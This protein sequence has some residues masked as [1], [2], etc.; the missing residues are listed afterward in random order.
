MWRWEFWKHA[1]LQSV[2]GVVSGYVL[3]LL[4]RHTVMGP[5][6]FAGVTEGVIGVVSGCVL[7]M[8][9]IKHVKS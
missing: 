8:L 7:L 6:H 5:A 3:L 1:V 2:F 4:Y 9:Y